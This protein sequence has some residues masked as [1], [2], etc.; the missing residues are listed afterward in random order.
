MRFLSLLFSW[1]YHRDVGFLLL[2]FAK[3]VSGSEA[4]AIYLFLNYVKW[5][6]IQCL[7]TPGDPG[8]VSNP[9]FDLR[10]SLESV[11][12]KTD[13]VTCV[14][15]WPLH[16]IFYTNWFEMDSLQYVTS[17]TKENSKD[18]YWDASQNVHIC[19]ANVGLLNSCVG[20]E[21]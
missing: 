9:Y 2:D 3:F 16:W 15:S 13:W 7:P 5:G 20:T 17:S 19:G 14:K 8:Y 4:T 10:V 6:F 1:R 12:E 21:F 11:R 18:I